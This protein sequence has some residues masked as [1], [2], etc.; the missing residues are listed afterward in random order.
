MS[1]LL[2]AL[3]SLVP[4]ESLPRTGWIQHGISTPETIS[5]HLVGVGFVALALA[6]RV[7]PPLDVDRVVALCA[8]HDAPEA[9]LGD[10]PR[11]A[12]EL[13]PPGAKAHAEREAAEALLGPLS[14]LAL[15]RFHEAAEMRTRESRFAKLCDGLQLGVRLLAY[16]RAGWGG[17]EDFVTSLEQ[18][19]CTEFG[20]ADELRQ[21]IL[22]S[23]GKSS[24]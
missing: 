11:P 16:R 20:P 18:L 1:E 22:V 14:P 4:L 13:L 19:D 12:A 6:P 8:V 3:L 24:R 21:Q 9:L 5:G 10:I 2:E 23:L 7:S 17:L 15:E